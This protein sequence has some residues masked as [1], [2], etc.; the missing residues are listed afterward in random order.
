MRRLHGF[1]LV[2]AG[3]AVFFVGFAL[4]GN[5]WGVPVFLGGLAIVAAGVAVADRD[6]GAK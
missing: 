1:L 2:A 3:A 5:G 4:V 6:R